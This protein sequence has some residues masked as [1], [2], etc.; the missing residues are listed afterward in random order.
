[1]NRHN[2]GVLYGMLL[3]DG[4]IHK[5]KQGN[6][7]FQFTHSEKQE[8]YAVYKAKKINSIIGGKKNIPHKYTSDT[9]YGTITY[10]KYG[11][12]NKYFNV[13]RRVAYPNGKKTYTRK[14]LNFLTPEGIAY[15]YMDDGG[16]SKNFRRSKDTNEITGCS[17]EMRISTY[18]T[19]EEIECIIL[20][21]LE[22]WEIQAKK[23]LSK[24]HGTYYLAFNTKES[25][26][27]ERLIG[28]YLIESMQYKLP[29]Y[30]LT[31]AQN[32]REGDDIV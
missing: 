6:N 15:W 7:V 2:R 28:K 1:M 21:F 26:K 16:V 12:S 18:C 27:L 13:M 25:K 5:I 14:L 11:K 17:V 10:V 9:K 32:T 20:Y 31:R 3:G 24:K 22:V 29:S 23:R 4:S 8:D 30:W 19:L